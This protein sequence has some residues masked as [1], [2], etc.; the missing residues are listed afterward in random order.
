MVT[1]K[2]AVKKAVNIFGISLLSNSQ[3]LINVLEDLVPDLEY[4]RALVTKYYTDDIGNKFRNIFSEK[5]EKNEKLYVLESELKKKHFN[6]QDDISCFIAFFT[7]VLGCIEY[8]KYHRTKSQH[9]IVDNEPELLA[10][11][12][13]YQYKPQSFIVDNKIDSQTHDSNAQRSPPKKH[14][15]ALSDDSD[16]D[17]AMKHYFVNKRKRRKSHKKVIVILIMIIVSAI[18]F[19]LLIPILYPTNSD[20]TYVDY[21]S[22]DLNGDCVVTKEDLDILQDYL[23][24]IN[25]IPEDKLKNAD[26]DGDGKITS[27][28]AL[29]MKNDLKGE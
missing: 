16:I 23:M 27:H 25:S 7:D 4:E 11:P 29:L 2:G 10:V 9:S 6:E 13:N 15:S 17:D 14:I 28:D 24:D 5:N 19:S 26:Y 20:I 1:I 8:E 12:L 21:I 3:L 22:G 18:I